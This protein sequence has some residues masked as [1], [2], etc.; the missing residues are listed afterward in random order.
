MTTYGPATGNYSTASIIAA[1]KSGGKRGDKLVRDKNGKFNYVK[2]PLGSPQQNG[3]WDASFNR[4]SNASSVGGFDTQSISDATLKAKNALLQQNYNNT[5]NTLKNNYDSSMNLYN[6]QEGK[7]NNNYDDTILGINKQTYNDVER[8]KLMSAQRGVTNSQQGLASDQ[9]MIR[10][11]NDNQNDAT[12]QR[13]DLL[14]D[15]A[16]QIANLTNTFNNSKQTAETNFGL[17]KTQNLNE[18]LASKLGADMDMWKFNAGND[19]TE[20][21]AKMQN[22]FNIDLSKLGFEQQK[23]LTQLSLDAQARL[24][25]VSQ[26]GSQSNFEKQLA[27]EANLNTFGMQY[28][29]YTKDMT[30]TQQS[31]YYSL[32]NKLGR[33]AISYE[34][35]NSAMDKILNPKITGV[36][37]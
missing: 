22:G 15:L 36:G 21:M 3:N 11:G 28:K 13:N 35:A 20:K 19:F 7:I 29:G 32:V 25:R 16:T 17:G 24:A 6:D 10:Q 33:G 34:D 30:P 9:S 4:A 1:R 2:D 23:A 14:N 37:W 27:L 26:S 31:Q 18:A 5:N 12:K 8:S